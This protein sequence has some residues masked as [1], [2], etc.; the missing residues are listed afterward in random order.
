MQVRYFSYKLED[1]SLI[2]ST[3]VKTKKIKPGR[4]PSGEAKLGGFWLDSLVELVNSKFKK[5]TCLFKRKK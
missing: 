4:Q 1:L 5:E 3:H 2:P